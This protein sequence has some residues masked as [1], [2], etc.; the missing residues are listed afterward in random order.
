MR[1]GV[2][3]RLKGVRQGGPVALDAARHPPLSV[4]TRGRSHGCDEARLVRS[5]C[6]APVQPL[7]PVE[8]WSPG[9]PAKGPLLGYA[10]QVKRLLGPHPRPANTRSR[11]SL[12]ITCKGTGPRSDA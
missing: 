8:S 5:C 3:G 4:L 6:R 1:V 9:G 7:S 10:E 11:V 2:L 12:T